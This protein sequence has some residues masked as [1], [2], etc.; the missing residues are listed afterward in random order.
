VARRCDNGHE[1]KR[2][3]INLNLS[4]QSREGIAI[5][6]Y[7]IAVDGSIHDGQIYSRNALAQAEFLDYAG[8]GLAEVKAFVQPKFSPDVDV[9]HGWTISIL[10]Q[11]QR[12]LSF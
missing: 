6:F 2:A 11:Q 5:A 9:T 3:G 12:C 4:G 1:I 8:V 7:F 10:H